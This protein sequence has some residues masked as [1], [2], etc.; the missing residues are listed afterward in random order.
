MSKY[1]SGV[2]AVE[3]TLCVIRSHPLPMHMSKVKAIISNIRHA[4]S[5]AWR[6][7]SRSARV[8]KTRTRCPLRTTIDE[9]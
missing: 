1:E 4:S 8:V 2:V 6:F 5:N 3:H 7:L 9:S